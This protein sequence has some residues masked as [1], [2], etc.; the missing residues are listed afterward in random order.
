[1]DMGKRLKR[2]CCSVLTAAVLLSALP[3]Q[4]SAQQNSRT[5]GTQEQGGQSSETGEQSGQASGTQ[6][7]SARISTSGQETV[8]FTEETTYAEICKLYSEK[9]YK[10]A[11]GESEIILLPEDALVGGNGSCLQSSV[12][13]YEGPALKTTKENEYVEWTFLTESDGLYEI[14]VE[15]MTDGGNGAKIQ[16]SLLI[17][18][19]V[20]FQEANN[21]S[22]YRRYEEEEGVTTNA[23]GDQVWPAIR[24]IPVW[25]EMDVMDGKGYYAQ[26]LRFYLT[27]G[28]HTLRIG[29]VDQN[30]FLGK[31]T[32]RP[33]QELPS[34]EEVKVQYDSL[35]Y[36]E[37]A[38]TAPV[39][40]QAEDAGWRNS[41]IIRR[42][43]ESDPKCE[44]SSFTN[45]V[46]N[47]I[48]G[49]RWTE[50]NQEISWKFNITEP[51][52]YRINMKIRQNYNEGMP[53]YRR[54]AIDGE[55]P[56]RELEE[57]AFP[58]QEDVWEAC[59]LQ[60]DEGEPYLFY[61]EPGEHEI[62]MTVKVGRIKEVVALTM[63]YV[64][65]LSAVVRKVT[66]I[67]GTEPDVNYE[68][69][70]YRAIPELA[71]ELT[72]VAD[73]LQQCADI[74]AEMTNVTS[75]M[76]KN[77][78]DI[79]YKLQSFA[80]DT[81]RVVE[82]FSD[83]TE[84]QTNLGSYLLD[85]ADMPL[86]IDYFEVASSGS[87]M[88]IAKA[89]FFEKLGVTFMNF[90]ASFT[91]DYDSIGSQKMGEGD[92][93]IEVWIARGTEWGEI[94]KN[95]VDEDFTKKTGINVNVNIIPSGQLNAG[96]VS[97]LML[98]INS[99]KAPDVALGVDY[100]SPAEFAFRDAVVDISEFA[101]FED[102][103][104]DFYETMFIP[105]TYEGGVYALPETMDF[106][107]LIYRKDIME[108]LGLSIPQTWDQLYQTTLPKLYENNMGF[109]FPVDSTASSN[110]PSSLR[111]MTMLLAQNGGSYYTQDGMMSG[112]D[113]A[114]AF[115]AFDQWTQ[116]Y[117]N[118]GLDAESN[119]F[120]RM[121]TGTMPIGVGEYGTYMKFLNAAPELYG[122]WGIAPMLGTEEEDGTINRSVGGISTTAGV[123][124]QQSEKQEQAWEFLKWWMSAETQIKFGREVEAALGTEARWNTANV[125]AFESLPW[126]Q[127]DLKII[128]EQMSVAQ[129]QP[130]VLGGYFTTRHLVNAWNRVVLGN[131]NPRDALEEAV[132][133]INKE[134]RTKHEEYG[135]IYDD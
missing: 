69:N 129:E 105:Y 79:V 57:Y 19:E 135:F 98:S 114:E 45:R 50:G 18:G 63:D 82:S 29:Y 44:P 41:S 74:F 14:S 43:S 17:D 33:P 95:L 12:E 116:L 133:E 96:S 109:S 94:L 71:D 55:V 21:I 86:S 85:M 126:D 78:L 70:L 127:E 30:L 13:G 72:Y 134:L 68:Y 80:E 26:P 119:F 36:K 56:F 47:I 106:T 107:V 42:E 38:V 113:S 81:E 112:L 101:D 77:Y 1:M 49:S 75:T 3:Q 61:L 31:V 132:V 5:S 100:S 32:I 130:I 34:Y 118:Y 84:M 99:G 76:E 67:T 46:L 51:G 53:S 64:E 73:G 92:K 125:E 24:E 90:L 39:K 52:L 121:R 10:Y 48:G 97:M 9:G 8:T 27:K 93:T 66:K 124:M 59:T 131:Q 89:N 20:P 122:R 117:T 28:S 111:G 11:S 40:F 108:E 16:R 2:L 23:I 65:Y 60:D 83:L 7:Q 115:R 62:T 25:Q 87:E 104:K 54:I 35:G 91:K 58:Y 123:I 88:K 4:V 102:V 22:F 15:Y 110:S 37:A 6:E 120:T 103:K 128:K